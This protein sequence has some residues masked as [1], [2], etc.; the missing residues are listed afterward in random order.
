MTAQKC[1]PPSNVLSCFKLWIMLK[2]NQII[3]F[4]QDQLCDLCI[5]CEEA[6]LY[7]SCKKE[8]KTTAN[9]VSIIL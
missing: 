4:P 9:Y 8:N 7:T 6:V 3:L 5:R 1:L 2:N